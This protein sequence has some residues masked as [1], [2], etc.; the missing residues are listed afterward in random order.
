MLMKNIL[1][2]I[3]LAALAACT[4]TNQP[5][6]SEPKTVSQTP[7]NQQWKLTQFQSFSQKDLAQAVLDLREL[8]RAHAT[9]G[10]NQMGFQA[11][12]SPE[13]AWQV[14]AIA[15][16]RMYCEEVAALETAF[17][18]SIQAAQTYRLENNRLI[19]QTASGETL[20]FE[21]AP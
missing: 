1:S 18:K 16:T 7:L 13:N 17:A 11:A 5:H 14:K 15:M 20:I 12:T 2:A 10:C 8:P 21:A 6:S 9:V 19:L 4:T 3:V